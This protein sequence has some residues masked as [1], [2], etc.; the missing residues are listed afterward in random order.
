M[1]NSSDLE[2]AKVILNQF[3]DT[4]LNDLEKVIKRYR[5]IDAW[6]KTTK[7]NED[8][9]NHLQ[10]IMISSGVLDEKVDY[11]KLIYNGK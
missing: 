5:E 3:P 10:D 4:S 6:P 7:F 1:N 2:V 9:F 8:S 11:S